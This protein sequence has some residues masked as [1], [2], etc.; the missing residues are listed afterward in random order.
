VPRAANDWRETALAN[1]GKLDFDRL[2][3]TNSSKVFELARNP[4]NKLWRIVRPLDAR[5][6]SPKIDK[7]LQELCNLR[8][9]QFV[10]DGPKIEFD[11]YGLQNPALTLAFARGTNTVLSLAFGK[12]PTNDSS[13]VFA[14]RNA[15]QTVVTVATNLLEPLHASYETLRDTQLVSA[16]GPLAAIEIRGQE[17]FTLLRTNRTWFVV[18]Q[19]FF[20]DAGLV[21][22]MLRSLSEIEVKFYND[23]V[24]APELPALGLVPPSYQIILRE[25]VTNASVI[26]NVPAEEIDF[27]TNQADMVFAQRADEKFLYTVKQSDVD[28]L[29]KTALELRDR[30]IWHFTENDV[31][32]VTIE[33]HGK[34]LQLV[35][36]GTNQ[37]S[38]AVGSQGIVPNEFALEET[39]HRFGE[40]KSDYWIQRGDQDRA[41]FGFK[42]DGHRIT[43]DLKDGKKLSVELGSFASIGSPYALV[44]QD[45]GPWVFTFPPVLYQFV[46]LYLTIPPG[47]P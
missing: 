32:R 27:G 33:Q 24:V 10:T 22:D 1:L 8:V 12:S 9:E 2:S 31:A 44:T 46:Q 19:N 38:I 17:N 11:S 28:R 7:A 15:E 25:A 39:V 23:V 3:V 29:P 16:T 47:V 36:N 6:D 21:S 14:R 40:L 5:A 37:W 20:A 42:P 34:S 13:R 26:T 30:R 43:F 4:S 45:D 41:R 35:R 18:P